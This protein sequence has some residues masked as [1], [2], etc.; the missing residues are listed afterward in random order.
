MRR[1]LLPTLLLATCSH[2]A[3]LA[4][5]L[6]P[7]A[8]GGSLYRGLLASHAEETATLK[9]TIGFLGNSSANFKDTELDQLNP[10]SAG[11]FKQ[12]Y[13]YDLTYCGT[14][15]ATAAIITEFTGEWTAGGSPGGAA[16]ELAQKLGALLVTVEHRFYGCSRP[17]GGCS[18]DSDATL[19]TRYLSVEQAVADAGDFIAYFEAFSAGGF[20]PEAAAAAPKRLP[21]GYKATRRWGIVGGSYAG[22]YVS[23]ITVRHGDLLAGTWAS[24][25]V[26]NAIFNFT[27]FD[28]TVS[29]AVGDDCSDALREVM[30]VFEGAWVN[31]AQRATMLELFH[32][33]PGFHTAGDFAWMLADSAG[34]APQYGSKAALCKYLNSTARDTPSSPAP[35][36][37]GFYLRGWAALEAFAAWTNDHYGSGFGSS[38]YYSTACLALNDAGDLSDGTTWVWQCCS[39]LGAWVVGASAQ[40]ALL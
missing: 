10:G 25:G 3:H 8:R 30:S 38:C 28:S 2:G 4:E 39:E 22:A 33:P 13:F 24:S 32:A 1:L 34:M 35:P 15:C 20:S 26:V 11:T 14:S 37:P 31:D 12:R 36:D 21:E 19:M 29:A 18:P 17:G 23:W 40:G 7:H 5:M 16:A 9:R 27:S 6:P